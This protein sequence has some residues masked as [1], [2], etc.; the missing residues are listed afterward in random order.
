MLRQAVVLVG[1][2]GTRLGALTNETPK[3]M[4]PIQG[5]PFLEILLR[6]IA[7]YGFEDIILLAH[8]HVHKIRERFDGARIGPAKI[9]IVTEREKAG[10]GGALREA[11]GALEGTFLL[12]NGDSI[13]DFNYLALYQDFLAANA[14][15]AIALREV[16]DVSRYGHVTLDQAGRI[17]RFSEKSGSQGQSGLIGGGIYILD[18][19]VLERIGLG[20]ISLE[21]D[22]LPDLVTDN[23]VVGTPFKGFFL[24]IGLPE[25]FAEAQDSVPAWERR[26]VIFFDRDGT[27]NRDAGY[28]HLVDDLEFLPGVPEVIRRCND[29][30]RFVIVVSNQAGIARGFY[31]AGDVDKFHR[32]MNRRLQAHGAHIDAFYYCPHHPEGTV[33]ALAKACE[34]RKPGK[35]MLANACRDWPIDLDDAVLIGDK[36]IDMDAARAYGIRGLLTD[37]TDLLDCFEKA[38]I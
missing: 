32:E 19:R 1:G 28:T 36:Q 25:T 14:T 26:K 30:G 35:G 34:C 9:R 8:H 13:F 17:V 10:T 5:T 33:A 29:A 20:D 15:V 22:V 4:L 31:S 11:A 21:T 3:P 6:N 16:Q 7:R 24:D 38:G 23:E 12:A 27:L 2:A 18:R 37:G